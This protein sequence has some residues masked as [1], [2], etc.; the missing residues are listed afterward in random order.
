MIT[1]SD[2]EDGSF[3]SVVFDDVI[4]KS[5]LRETIDAVLEKCEEQAEAILL[6]DLSG[7]K[8]WD[9]GV[10]DLHRAVALVKNRRSTLSGFRTAIVASDSEAFGMSRMLELTLDDELDL[11]LKVVRTL[12][13]A[14]QWLGLPC[15]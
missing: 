15:A 14:K 4:T 13:E 5:E 7:V 11:D 6:V 9:V 10:T 8:R 3:L 1:H 2:S 12:L